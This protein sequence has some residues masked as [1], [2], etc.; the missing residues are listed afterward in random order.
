[1]KNFS[2]FVTGI[3]VETPSLV[4]ANVQT[5]VTLKSDIEIINRRDSL[6]LWLYFEFFSGGFNDPDITLSNTSSDDEDDALSYFAK[7]A[8]D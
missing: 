5:N 8:E 7:L 6:L 1:M 4:E 2:P 3:I